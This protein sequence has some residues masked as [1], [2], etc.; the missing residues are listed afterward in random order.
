MS[1]NYETCYITLSNMRAYGQQCYN[2]LDY[3]IH[4]SLSSEH[5][6]LHLQHNFLSLL[7]GLHLSVT[8]Y[9]FLTFIFF[10]SPSLHLSVSASLSLSLFFVF[11]LALSFSLSFPVTKKA[12]LIRSKACW[13]KLVNLK[14]CLPIWSS[15]IWSSAHRSKALLAQG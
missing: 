7:S 9:F 2:F 1:Q 5:I 15:P 3:F 4:F 10:I 8:P 12:I 14:F 6:S 11:F 13:L